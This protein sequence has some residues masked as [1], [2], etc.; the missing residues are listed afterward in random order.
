[1]LNEMVHDI[2]EESAKQLSNNIHIYLEL[3]ACY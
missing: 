2:R 3:K 1:M